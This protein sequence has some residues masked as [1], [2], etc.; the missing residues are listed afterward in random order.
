MALLETRLPPFYHLWEVHLYHPLTSVWG[1]EKKSL[2][3]AY[4]LDWRSTAD[5]DYIYNSLF[6]EKWGFIF[7]LISAFWTQSPFLPQRCRQLKPRAAT[8]FL[9]R[10]GCLPESLPS[11]GRVWR[12]VILFGMHF[13]VLPNP[14]HHPMD[15]STRPLARKTVNIQPCYSAPSSPSTTSPTFSWL[16]QKM[17]GQS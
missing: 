3:K 12:D 10:T 6:T 13:I 5:C 1:G 8:L 17:L 7:G 9:H 16:R 11:A 15:N 4:N 14:E 2:S